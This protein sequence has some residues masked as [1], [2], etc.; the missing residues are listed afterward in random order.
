MPTSYTGGKP[1]VCQLAMSP[2]NRIEV[3]LSIPSSGVQIK[4]PLEAHK[5]F[6]CVLPWKNFMHAKQEVLDIKICIF[7]TKHIAN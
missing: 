5:K 2:G 1:Y 3:L 6:I 4:F 7:L